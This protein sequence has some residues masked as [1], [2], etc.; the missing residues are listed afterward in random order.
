M[1]AVVKVIGSGPRAVWT[2]DECQEQT[3]VFRRTKPAQED[4]LE[5]NRQRHPGSVSPVPDGVL[6]RR[7]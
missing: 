5:H 1:P 4:A 6:D 3:A 2:C 7:P